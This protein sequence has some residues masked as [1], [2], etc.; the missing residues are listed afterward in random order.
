MRAILNGIYYRSN[1]GLWCLIYF[2]N[3]MASTGS[4]A[5]DIDKILGF[6]SD[7]APPTKKPR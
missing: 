4:Q 1:C 7:G 3:W 6:F 5:S 2:R